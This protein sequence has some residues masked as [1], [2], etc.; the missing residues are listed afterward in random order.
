MSDESSDFEPA[1]L[2]AMLSSEEQDVENWKPVAGF[3]MYDVSDMGRVRSWWSRGGRS[4]RKHARNPRLLA[5]RVSSNGYV[6]ARVT[7]WT[8]EREE[9]WV[10]RLVL[11]AFSRSAVDSG[12][13]HHIDGC[14]T[15][16][17]LS[18]LKWTTPSEN[19]GYREPVKRE[20]TA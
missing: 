10:H 7:K 2:E 11:E 3:E 1:R 6:T 14:T 8:R 20:A 4:A 17:R 9:R 19:C 15:N 16:N 12:Q 18:N 5:L 13:A